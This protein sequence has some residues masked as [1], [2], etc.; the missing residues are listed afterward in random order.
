ML[1]DDSSRRDAIPFTVP[2]ILVDSAVPAMEASSA[3]RVLAGALA[4][5][6]QFGEG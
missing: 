3:R 2:A 4:T 1:C 6:R 5:P